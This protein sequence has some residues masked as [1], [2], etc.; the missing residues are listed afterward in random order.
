MIVNKLNIH[1]IVN[2]KILVQK[3]CLICNKLFDVHIGYFWKNKFCSRTCYSEYRSKYLVGDKASVYTKTITQCTYCGKEMLLRKNHHFC[4][5][6]CYYEFRKVYYVGDKLYN[7]GLIMSDEYKE[8]CRI[9]TVKA[10]QNGSLNRQTIPQQKVNQMLDSLNIKYENEKNYKYYA[11]DNYLCDS[12]LIIEV[13]GD[14]YHANPCLYS[15]DRVNDMQHKDIIRDKRK[16]TYISKYHNIN[17]LYIWEDDIK[18]HYNK[19]VRLI[20]QYIDNKGVLLDYQSFNYD[21]DLKLNKTIINP[22][23]IENP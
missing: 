10:Y 8:Q 22:Y 19:C 18:H 6:N 5:K 15:L 13:M 4:S 21:D 1:N 17:I 7:T 14:Y 20:Q 9:N 11:V 12:N 23:F 16:R 2:Q 3:H